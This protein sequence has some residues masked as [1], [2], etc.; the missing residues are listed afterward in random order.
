MESLAINPP[1]INETA[2][3]A[4]VVPDAPNDADGTMIIPEDQD[5]H[6][7]F[8]EWAVDEALNS[9]PVGIIVADENAQVLH[10]NRAADRIIGKRD[11]LLVRNG[12]LCASARN[13]TDRLRRVIRGV[14][15]R[16][17]QGRRAVP[18]IVPLSR[19]AA[20]RPLH[21]VVKHIWCSTGDAPGEHTGPLANLIISDPDRRMTA[22]AELIG[23]CFN[24]T[25]AESIVLERLVY[26]LSLQEIADTIGTSRN[27]V[28]NQ[29]QVVFEKTGTN[30]QPELIRLVLSTAI[31]LDREPQSSVMRTD[32]L[33]RHTAMAAAAG[34]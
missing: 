17:K 30:R 5:E 13:D 27:T 6:P 3:E 26:G 32:P 12:Q 10:S 15:E 24:L 34:R 8:A 22:P 9:V 4:T 23:P 31:W 2:S 33:P 28:R 1:Y 7:I 19:S 29:L 20:E 14:I 18:G 21:I 11:G 25:P 16:A